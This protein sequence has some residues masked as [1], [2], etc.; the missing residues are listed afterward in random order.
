MREQFNWK[1]RVSAISYL[2]TAR[3][4]LRYGFMD[5]KVCFFLQKESY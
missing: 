1:K 3:Y 5:R 4:T 2:W